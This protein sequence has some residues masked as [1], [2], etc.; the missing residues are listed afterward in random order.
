M[1]F[2]IRILTQYYPPLMAQQPPVG[3]GLLSIEA[4]RSHSDTL[5]SVGLF[6]TSDQPDAETSTWHN[7]QQTSKLPAGFEPAIPT[8]EW[9]QTQPL[10]GAVTEIGTKYH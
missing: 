2:L 4:S 6:C 8:S 1:G 3:Q 5:H 10:D 9:P 7:T